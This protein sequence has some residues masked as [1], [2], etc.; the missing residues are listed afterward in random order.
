MWGNLANQ[1]KFAYAPKG[2]F[3]NAPTTMLTPYSH[4]LLAVLNSKLADWYFRLIGVERDGGY[5]EYKPMFIQR[6][7]IPKIPADEQA[8]FVELVE[9]ILAAKGS[10]SSADTSVWEGELDALVYALYGLSGAE[11]AAV[12]GG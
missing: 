10:D 8:A 12:A 11:R 1:A 9:R 6:I 4:Y 5:Y 3:V 2:M 7:P